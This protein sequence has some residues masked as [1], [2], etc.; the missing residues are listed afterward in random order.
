VKCGLRDRLLLNE[1]WLFGVDVQ[2]G[3]DIDVPQ[4]EYF[5]D[6]A[7]Q[8]EPDSQV[9]LYMAA[10]HWVYAKMSGEDHTHYNESNLAFLEKKVL[11]DKAKVSTFIARNQHHGNVFP[12]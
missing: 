12:G 11:S 4:I 5:K 2:L 10:P 1:W 6:I 9:T 3:S 7:A 8:M